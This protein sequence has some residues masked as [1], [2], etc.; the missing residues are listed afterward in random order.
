MSLEQMEDNQTTNGPVADTL[1]AW[2]QEQSFPGKELY[3]LQEN[4]EL[5]LNA[6]NGKKE[7]VIT[8]LAA[9]G[10]EHTLKAL[11]D[12]YAEVEQK[13][14]ELETEW[15]SA[16][17]KLKMAGK[18]ERLNDYL[19]S[20]VAIGNIDG[21]LSTVQGWE[22]T[23]TA[24][25]DEVYNA[26][27]KLAEEAEALADSEK[28]KETTQAFKEITDKWKQSS[29]PDKHRQDILWNRIEAARTKFYDRK[30]RQ[31][32][33]HEHEMLQNLDLKME[34]VDKA[35]QLAASEKWK[36][37]SEGFRQLMEQWKPIGRTLPDKNEALWN[38]FIAAKN[39]FFDRKKAHADN[40]QK[41]QDANYIVKLALVEQAEALKDSTDWNGTSQAYA[42]IL[43]QWKGTGRVPTEKSDE[44]WG[45]MTAAKDK[46][47]DAK[48]QHLETVRVSLEDNLAQ[49]QAILKR[50][51]ALK[52][53]TH[54]HDGTDEMNELMDEWK[55]IGPVPRAL[56]NAMWE[57]FLSARK[58]F[59]NRKDEYRDSRKK[60]AI[61]HQAS[62]LSQSREFIQKLQEEIKEEEERI[63]DFNEGLKNI[64]PGKKEQELREHLQKLIAQGEENI[65]R[66][67]A[68]V[69]NVEKELAQMEHKTKEPNVDDGNPAPTE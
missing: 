28:W 56:S 23:I 18:V 24:L 9:Q 41:E 42:A 30:R 49:K 53:S 7:R 3:T 54:W 66:R 16:D 61:Q 25:S 67:K 52:N 26:K 38:R 31:Q 57:Q 64:T 20:M 10:A 40:I 37:A 27:L 4:G 51:E 21:L 62:R 43:E 65:A 59:F 34:L 58:H 33:A 12:K 69:E 2:W 44:L 60:H 11:R 14:K 17:D 50:A 6:L 48:R 45:R 15:V 36:D 5:V 13:V 55:K 8:T 1:Q 32:E 29:M 46:F 39:V 22:Q 68:K 19:L 35:E 63:A 47:F